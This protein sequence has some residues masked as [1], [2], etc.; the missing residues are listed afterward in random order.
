ME[1]PGEEILRKREKP[2]NDEDGP[3]SK[4]KVKKSLKDLDPTFVP[5]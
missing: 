2:E 1:K 3:V 5:K 4:D